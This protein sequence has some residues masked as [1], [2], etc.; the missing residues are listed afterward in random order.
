[1]SIS[2][3]LVSGLSQVFVAII[4]SLFAYGIRY[5]FFRKRLK[6]RSFANYIGIQSAKKQID[7]KFLVIW[8]AV[9]LFGIIS[10]WINFTVSDSFRE[11]LM[12]Q[13]SPY[14]KILQ[15]G[16][17]VQGVL[18]ALIYCFINSGGAEE[19]LF[20][21][22]IAKRMFSMFGFSIGN[23]VQAFIFWIMHLVIFYL[24][25]K[26]WFS[27]LQVFAFLTSFGL[28]LLLGYVNFRRNGE[29]ILPSWILHSSTNFAT[30]L[31]LAAIWPR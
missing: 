9:I 25:T 13:N 12:S 16:F 8:G 1:M 22:L 28:G 6:K 23:I 29:S 19:I 17:N 11:M 30:F 3:Q 18:L 24:M 4:L 27:Y 5:L 2:E 31:T 14:G 20:R 10:T 26:E 15:G 21:G 7:F